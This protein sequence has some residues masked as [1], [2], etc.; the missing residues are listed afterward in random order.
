[1][2]YYGMGNKELSQLVRKTLKE[3]GF[4]SKDVSVRV[5]TSVI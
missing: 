4:T 1:M 3:H 5:K 2:S